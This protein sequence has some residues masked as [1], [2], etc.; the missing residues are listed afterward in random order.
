MNILLIEPYYT[1]SHKN[2]AEEL[3]KYSENNI[4][5]IK[6]SGKFWKWRM[7]GG[8]IT[9][10][11]RFDKLD[12]KPD[13]ILATDMLDLNSFLSLTRKKTVN[14]PTALY[15]HENQLSYP[16]SPIDRD[17]AKNRDYHYSFINYISA[18]CADKVF[19]NSKYHKDIFFTELKRFLKMFPDNNELSSIGEI[20]KK[21]EVLY[22][23]LDLKKYD[24]HKIQKT[25]KSPLILWNHRWEYD[26]NPD[27]FIN[28]LILLADKGIDFKA[29]FLG[30][31]FNTIPDIFNKAKERLKDRI[32]HFG[33]VKE[34]SEYI[35]WLWKADIIPV[36]SNHDFFG[37]SIVQ[38]IYCNTIPL[39]PKRLTYPEL[40][41]VKD[42]SQYYYNDYNDLVKKLEKMLININ[43]Y[44]S[45]QHEVEKFDW[46]KMIYEYDIKFK[47]IV[48]MIFK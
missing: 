45:L 11:K 8:A 43:N 29:V 25:K 6:L 15:F 26:K 2:W 3:Q 14:I 27:D 7:H 1:G 13:L 5:I 34:Y 48:K 4:E 28:A 33:Y 40:I 42:H 22:L 32:V 16:W 31:Y 39:L 21:S 30:E 12:F 18:Y 38:A 47:Q 17:I 23:G 37:G 44:K 35:K 19:F 46:S 24:E 9:L 10:A 41:P 36:T 20:L